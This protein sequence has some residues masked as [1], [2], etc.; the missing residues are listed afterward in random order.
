MLWWQVTTLLNDVNRAATTPKP[1]EEEM[2]SLRAEASSKG[3]DVKA[4]KGSGDKAAVE[5]ALGELMVAKARVTAGEEALALS[6]D[7]PRRDDGTVD[8]SKDFFGEAAYLTVSGQLNGEMYACAL[9]DIYTFGPTFRC[10]T[11]AL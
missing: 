10:A 2:A 5:A 9:S 3:A 4:A 8:C 6:P 11:P 7:L 1:S